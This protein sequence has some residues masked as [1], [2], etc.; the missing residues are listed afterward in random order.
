MKKYL[1]VNE[2]YIFKDLL[3]QTVKSYDSRFSCG[4][5][6]CCCSVSEF[7][8]ES[9]A[10]VESTIKDI[11]SLLE[12]KTYKSKYCD[13]SDFEVDDCII[14][15]IKHVLGREHRRTNLYKINSNFLG[16]MVSEYI[17]NYIKNEL[18]RRLE[19]YNYDGQ[20]LES[21]RS[22][23][24]I[25]DFLKD[26][27][28]MLLDE[29]E[30]T[31]GAKN[32]MKMLRNALEKPD[33]EEDKI[34]MLLSELEKTYG[35][36]DKIIELR[37]ELE[38]TDYEEYKIAWLLDELEK[39]Y[40]IK[41]KYVTSINGMAAFMKFYLFKLGG[42]NIMDA[43]IQ[44]YGLNDFAC[45]ILETNGLCGSAGYYWGRGVNKSDL[46]QDMMVS[47]YAQL[48][49][50]D[51]K[52]AVG[53]AELVKKLP[54][55]TASDFITAYYKYMESYVGKNVEIEPVSQIQYILGFLTPKTNK[56]DGQ[57]ES[58]QMKE[59]F[60]RSVELDDDEVIMDD[61]DYYEIRRRRRR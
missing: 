51:E 46:S 30:K 3:H 22:D 37:N 53:F 52:M 39:T 60:I 49:K 6:S 41:D 21:L 58:D 12:G 50:F 7:E 1:S 11:S 23:K 61:R 14:Y 9:G 16:F 45:H 35:A 48:K 4:W 8:P 18:L 38:K 36:K 32:E 31:D 44:K 42:K 29:L 28:I 54:L 47:I 17:Q 20:L 13:G 24:L 34:I 5:Y 40:E 33:R 55:L 57:R 27:I 59:S 2:E 25:S 26:E 15:L 56:T 43:L 10:R 19:S